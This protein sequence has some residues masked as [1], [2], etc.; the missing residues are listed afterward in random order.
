M[1]TSSNLAI[2]KRNK[3]IYLK[4]M[5]FVSSRRSLLFYLFQHFVF[6]VDIKSK[7][8][9]LIDSTSY[10]FVEFIAECNCPTGG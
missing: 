10:R 8:M 6:V 1:K 5:I 4:P 2:K 7:L 3:C 9:I